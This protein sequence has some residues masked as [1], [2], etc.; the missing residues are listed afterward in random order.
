M[1]KFN[2]YEGYTLGDT[3]VVYSL[4]DEKNKKMCQGTVVKINRMSVKVQYEV[5]EGVYY[6]GNFNA[7]KLFLIKK[8]DI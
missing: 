6:E 7:P 5:K 8:V 4:I 2:E 3:V 1:G